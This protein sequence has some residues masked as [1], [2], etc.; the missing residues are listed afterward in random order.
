MARTFPGD[1]ETGSSSG[2]ATGHRLGAGL[3][4]AALLIAASS[5]IA[6]DA[7][8]P[9]DEVMEVTKVNWSE[10]GGEF[11]ELFS[12]DRLTR[13][14]S[15]DFVALFRA[16]SDSEF[17]R[18]AGTPF[19][20]D[21]VVNA[22]DGCPLQDV[23]VVEGPSEGAVS[24]VLARYRFMACMGDTPDFQALSETRFDVVEEDGRAVIDDIRN[25]DGTGGTTS[26]KDEMKA[27]AAEN[28][29]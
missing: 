27:I 24:V 25:Q 2:N 29:N 26:L 3:V 5:A 21:V 17:A 4:V 20:Y 16:A 19:D 12:E 13:L 15:R 22:Q 7:T 6:A 8:A 14:Y 9:V 23:S 11:Q 1:V 10:D 28:A 18:E